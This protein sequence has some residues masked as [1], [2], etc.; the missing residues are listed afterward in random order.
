MGTAS[1][2]SNAEPGLD[3]IEGSKLHARLFHMRW[4]SASVEGSWTV[5]TKCSGAIRFTC[6]W[7]DNGM[8]HCPIIYA[9]LGQHMIARTGSGSLPCSGER[10]RLNSSSPRRASSLIV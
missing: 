2:P 8:N 4:D 7:V 9:R 3:S 1:F 6:L 5:T 10:G